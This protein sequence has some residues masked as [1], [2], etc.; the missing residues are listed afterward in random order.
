MAENLNLLEI[1][2]MLRQNAINPQNAFSVIKSIANNLNQ[3]NEVY[4]LLF[5][6]K[7]AQKEKQTKMSKRQIY[8]R[9]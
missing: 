4:F 2:N 3:K 9:N 5:N 8:P 7:Q 6:K 1:N